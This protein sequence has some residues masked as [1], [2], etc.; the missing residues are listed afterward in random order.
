M[1]LDIASKYPPQLANISYMSSVICEC[2]GLRITM[3]VRYQL[4]ARYV[5]CL[6]L[7]NLGMG[8]RSDVL[9]YGTSKDAREIL[10]NYEQVLGIVTIQLRG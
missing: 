9:A 2:F 1:I 10:H 5:T 7:E 4:E 3:P 8:Y 6:L